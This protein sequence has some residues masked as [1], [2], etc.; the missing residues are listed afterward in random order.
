MHTIIL[1][2]IL[3][4]IPQ[5]AFSD[6][7][8]KKPLVIFEFTNAKKEAS[9]FD[10]TRRIPEDVR[11]PSGEYDLKGL[12]RFPRS[13]HSY[14]ANRI[15]FGLNLFNNEA[16]LYPLSDNQLQNPKFPI[17]GSLDLNKF[18]F[19]A[20]ELWVTQK[21]PNCSFSMHIEAQDMQG[22]TVNI[23]INLREKNYDYQVNLPMMRANI[24]PRDIQYILSMALGIEKEDGW[25]FKE[26][27]DA[28]AYML[29]LGLDLQGIDSLDIDLDKSTKLLNFKISR[30][31]GG[32]PTDILRWDDIPKQ[33]VNLD[34]KRIVHLDFAAAI[35][36]HIPDYQHSPSLKIVEVIA[37]V[38]KSY[39]TKILQ[40]APIQSFYANYM[41]FKEFQDKAASL[42]SR[43]ELIA[44]EKWRWRVDLDALK[45][46]HPL[47]LK[48]LKGRVV[49]LKNNCISKLES[50]ELIQLGHK[51][52]PDIVLKNKKHLSGGLASLTEN[53]LE[54]MS[55]IGGHKINLGEGEFYPQIN[56]KE[57][58]AGLSSGQ[59]WLSI[60]RVSWNG[61]FANPS[62]GSLNSSDLRLDAVKF[63]YTDVPNDEIKKWYQGLPVAQ[64][65]QKIEWKSSFLCF[66]IL[67]WTVFR[68][69]TLSGQKYLNNIVSAWKSVASAL[70]L[71]SSIIIR[72]FWGIW[73]YSKVLVYLIFI[74]TGLYLL[75]YVYERF[76]FGDKSLSFFSILIMLILFSIINFLSWISS[77]RRGKSRLLKRD[78]VFGASNNSLVLVLSISLTVFLAIAFEAYLRRDAGVSAIFLFNENLLVVAWFAVLCYGLLPWIRSPISSF[79]KAC[80]GILSIGLKKFI[81]FKIIDIVIALLLYSLCLEHSLVNA[82]F[83]AIA[84]FAGSVFLRNYIL[85]LRLILYKNFPEISLNLYEYPHG[86]FFCAALIALTLSPIL[87][88]FGLNF[89]AQQVMNISFASLTLGISIQLYE[90]Y[91]SKKL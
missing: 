23:P 24:R 57:L 85:Q 22:A 36:K 47:G 58:M 17:N 79:I 13:D 43:L 46:A 89:M 63:I 21:S 15:K 4:V 34:G 18:L 2:A 1:L 49:P 8:E 81:K 78:W 27:L 11:V 87:Y 41:F 86:L 39:E 14:V 66:M 59:V 48:F 32:R 25:R 28:F 68:W 33:I 29:P 73:H 51:L 52:L 64:E 42:P 31:P 75:F 26:E 70:Q 7:T 65:N 74:F 80:K 69:G 45:L 91:K 38:P 83:I 44:P 62:F 3:L 55:V 84:A 67:L 71:H 54:V 50:V 61:S 37:F 72:V 30:S 10:S 6:N 16:L 20:D 53:H 12:F 88:I 9:P 5:I 56:K 76:G 82:N 60:G 35:K 77:Y 90:F 19:I 40:F